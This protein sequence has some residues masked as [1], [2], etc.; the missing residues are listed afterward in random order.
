[1]RKDGIGSEEF[2]DEQDV[3]IRKKREENSKFCREFENAVAQFNAIGCL[4]AHVV[5]GS[6]DKETED[7]FDS[8]GEIH[9]LLNWGDSDYEV[10]FVVSGEEAAVVLSMTSEPFLVEVLR[11]HEGALR[12]VLESPRGLAS[13]V[14]ATGNEVG[15]EDDDKLWICGVQAAIH[16]SGLCGDVLRD[17]LEDVCIAFRCI[18]NRLREHFS[19]SEE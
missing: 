7:F 19:D 11:S 14:L 2:D 8:I 15:E 13:L 18:G 10:S 6:S 3:Y 12:C 9:G 4:A 1:M 17:A 5:W 16:I